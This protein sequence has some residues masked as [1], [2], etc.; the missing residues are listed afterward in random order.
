M[1]KIGDYKGCQIAHK[2]NWNVAF[3]VHLR[4]NEWE[5]ET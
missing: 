2:E 3:K 1:T 4:L 5:S